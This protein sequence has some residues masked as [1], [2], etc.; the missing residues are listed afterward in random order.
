MST[1]AQLAAK[2]ST[3]AKTAEGKAKSSHNAK[4]EAA[5]LSEPKIQQ[6]T[7][8]TGQTVLLPTDEVAAYQKH[9]ARFEAEYKPVTDHEK[10][11]TQNIADTQWRL[12]RIFSLEQGI[13]AIGRAEFAGLYENEDSSVRAAMIDVKTF[14]IYQRQLNN[15][16]IQ[17]QRLRR[18]FDKDTAE[19]KGLIRVREG[20]QRSAMT[21]AL[22]NMYDAQAE[23]VPFDPREIGFEFSTAEILAYQAAAQR[24]HQINLGSY[25]SYMKRKAA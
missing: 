2:L 3:G 17:E 24:Q 8:L 9:V 21:A 23:G 25:Y 1:P 5:F 10:E 16:S 20:Q 11:L 19:L 13:Y 7:V 22:N 14:T 15:L 12:N 6:V 18:N 4:D